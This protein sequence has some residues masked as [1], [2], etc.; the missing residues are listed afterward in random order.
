MSYT[1]KERPNSPS[2]R[3]RDRVVEY[4][5][6][7]ALLKELSEF[8]AMYWPRIKVANPNTSVFGTADQIVVPPSGHIWG[9]YARNDASIEGGVSEAPAGVEVGRLLNVLG[10][11]PMR[12]TKRVSAISCSPS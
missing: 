10:S 6:T 2:R 8:G 9:M 3:S 4:V 11:R 12:S 5:R 1:A 7:T